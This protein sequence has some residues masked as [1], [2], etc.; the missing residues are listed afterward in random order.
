M[1]PSSITSDG[2]YSIKSDDAKIQSAESSISLPNSV[3]I[4]R[5]RSQSEV[6]PAALEIVASGRERIASDGSATSPTYV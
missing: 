4:S 1:S 5:S 6:N 2:R 3:H